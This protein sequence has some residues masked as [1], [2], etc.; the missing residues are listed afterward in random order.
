MTSY[1]FKIFATGL[2]KT[3]KGLE[4][5]SCDPYFK[6]YVNDGN[7]KVYTS[8]KISNSR[9]P[10][11]NEFT[12]PADTF[13]EHPK[14]HEIKI[15]IKDSDW[16]NDDDDVGKCYFKIHEHDRA[17]EQREGVDLMDGDEEA[18]KIYIAVTENE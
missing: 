3:D 10:T 18:G 2:P 4:G 7:D 15:K 14:L 9:D 8:E 17:Y 11:W 13:G 5:G 1:T 6:L 16:G 12:L